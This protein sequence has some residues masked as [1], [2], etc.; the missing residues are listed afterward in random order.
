MKNTVMHETLINHYNKTAFTHHYIFG[1]EFKGNI[2]AVETTSEVLPFVTTVESA[3]KGN[4]VALKYK[5]NTS[6]KALLMS[7]GAKVVCSTE[8]F[9]EMVRSSKY[10]RGEV[11]ERLITEMNGQRWVKDNVPYTVD[12]DITIDGIAYQ[13]KYEKATFINES[14]MI[15]MRG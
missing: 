15:R 9:E 8:Y 7:K 12:G 4:G 1:F 5:P 6:I 14:Q 10:N 3:G 11:Y 2:Y 13:I